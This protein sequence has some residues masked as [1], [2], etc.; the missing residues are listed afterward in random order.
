M[1]GTRKPARPRTMCS[2][3]GCGCAARYQAVVTEA[4]YCPDHGAEICA[5]VVLRP[6]EGIRGRLTIVPTPQEIPA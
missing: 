2:R 4:N 6:I 3:F 5:F 1:T